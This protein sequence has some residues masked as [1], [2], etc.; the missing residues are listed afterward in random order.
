MSVGEAV[1]RAEVCV[2]HSI[3][4]LLEY[5]HSSPISYLQYITDGMTRYQNKTDLNTLDANN[6]MV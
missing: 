6:V 4:L 2:Q 5:N 1:C 3:Q